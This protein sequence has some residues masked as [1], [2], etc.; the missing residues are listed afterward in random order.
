MTC[1]CYKCQHNNPNNVLTEPA[2]NKKELNCK[3]CDKLLGYVDYYP[4]EGAVCENC[5]KIGL[6]QHNR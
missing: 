1:F 3:G 6:E 2:W 4:D 5:Q